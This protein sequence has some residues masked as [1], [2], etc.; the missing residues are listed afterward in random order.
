MQKLKLPV[1]SDMHRPGVSIGL[2]AQKN[3]L[4]V[5]LCISENQS[6]I[7]SGRWRVVA[8]RY[9]CRSMVNPRLAVVAFAMVEIK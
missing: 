6:A 8:I 5:S 4:Q 2:R 1:F 9:T 7:A 3:C